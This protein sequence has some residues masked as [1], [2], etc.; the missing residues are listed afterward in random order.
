MPRAR[1]T[2]MPCVFEL[3]NLVPLGR[4]ADTRTS[5]ATQTRTGRRTTWAAHGDYLPISPPHRHV[6]RAR[7]GTAGRA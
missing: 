4:R 6:P 1:R 3:N 2:R 7:H 5:V